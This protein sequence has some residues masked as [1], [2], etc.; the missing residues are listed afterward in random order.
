M[1]PSRAPVAL[2]A[3]ALLL[4]GGAAACT[5]GT[6][7]P[8]STGTTSTGTGP[9]ASAGPT[10]GTT[11]GPSGDLSGGP[12]AHAAPADAADVRA[13]GT[14]LT[15]GDVTLAV[16]PAPGTTLV[17]E[18]GPDGSALARLTPGATAARS[19]VAWLAAPPDR[20]LVAEDDG[21]VVVTDAAGGFVAG[22][23]APGT[24]PA[25]DGTTSVPGPRG[26]GVVPGPDGTLAVMLPASPTSTAGT[27]PAELPLWLAATTVLD[28]RWGDRE[29]G[30]SLAVTPSAWA[31]VGG[32]AAAEGVWAQLVAREPE[33][34]T[35]SM[36]DQLWCHQLG[37]PT[38]ATW[39][40]EPWRPE[41]DTLELLAAGC[42]PVEQGEG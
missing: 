22:V 16:L 24:A 20:S 18:A 35:T 6:D 42:N 37:A 40:L 25:A 15:A 8:T 29:G 19:P 12:S 3:A 10:N 26:A 36:H 11:G 23:A 32:A 17:V 7:G 31:R 2:V 41:V 34:G 39:N 1:T 33:A 21:T 30:R 38:K 4:V 13:R 5:A 14:A 28:A 27:T 9:A